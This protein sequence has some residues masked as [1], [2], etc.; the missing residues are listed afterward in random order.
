M[1]L[2]KV[3]C[4]IEVR[5]IISNKVPGGIFRTYMANSCSIS[6]TDMTVLPSARGRA[7]G[8]ET[9][10]SRTGSSTAGRVVTLGA[11]EGSPADSGTSDSASV[12]EML[13]TG[14]EGVIVE[15]S[16]SRAPDDCRRGNGVGSAAV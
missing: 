15:F 10:R 1:I 5:P 11:I 12:T 9:N 8:L 13:E 7:T 3:A 2:L 6:S 4:S 16:T 14:P